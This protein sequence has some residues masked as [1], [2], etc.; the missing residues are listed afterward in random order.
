MTEYPLVG[1]LAAY[2][3]GPDT[4]EFTQR[5]DRAG[6]KWK[7]GSVR[8]AG[9][10]LAGI[11]LLLSACGHAQPSSVPDLPEWLGGSDASVGDP[12]PPVVCDD[13]GHIVQPGGVDADIA[14]GQL[15][16]RRLAYR[17]GRTPWVRPEA[18]VKA[19]GC[20]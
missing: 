1:E 5:M 18:L 10:L 8:Y 14:N 2:A 19:V 4:P 12:R 17:L 6:V 15:D 13:Q 9:G 11:V 16:N 7:R 3:I 20:P